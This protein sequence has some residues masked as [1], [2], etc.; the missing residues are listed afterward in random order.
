M[1]R[2]GDHDG[3]SKTASA[4]D[5]GHYPDPGEDAV[6]TYEDIAARAHQLWLAQG[7]PTDSAE[8]NWLEAERELQA[9]AKSRRLVAQVH[10]HAGSVQR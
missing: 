6:P 5:S 7:Q 1:D 3:K 4:A 9:S 10:E 8:R 2:H